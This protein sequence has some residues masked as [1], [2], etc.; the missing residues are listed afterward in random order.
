MRLKSVELN[1]NQL[2]K[3][4]RSDVIICKSKSDSD[5]ESKGL[6]GRIIN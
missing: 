6:A 5:S 3:M 1:E 4:K 2:K